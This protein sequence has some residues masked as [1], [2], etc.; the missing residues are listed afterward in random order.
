MISNVVMRSLLV[1]MMLCSAACNTTSSPLVVQSPQLPQE[2]RASIKDVL[3]KP[4]P[5]KAF[6]P[7]FND[8]LMD[9]DRLLTE[10]TLPSTSLP[11][12]TSSPNGNTK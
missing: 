3:T 12:A 5:S 7:L 4:S 2:M 8:L 11:A 9:I 1:T 6:E 10:A